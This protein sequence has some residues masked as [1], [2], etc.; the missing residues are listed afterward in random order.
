MQIYK[1]TTKAPRPYP[2]EDIGEY[3]DRL[4][5][6][7]VR[8]PARRMIKNEEQIKGCIEAGRINSL[9]LDAAARAVKE[10]G[11]TADIDR[12]VVEE[13]ARLGGRAACL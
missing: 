13:T 5:K 1:K 3:L 12:A 7:G 8:A 9:V 2:G 6:A 10:G 4:R 11:S